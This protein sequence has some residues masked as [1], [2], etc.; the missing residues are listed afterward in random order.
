MKKRKDVHA[1]KTKSSMSAINNNVNSNLKLFVD[2]P[3]VK[4]YIID[5]N[6]ALKTVEFH[7]LDWEKFL[8]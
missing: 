4:I 7:E 6:K 3:H 5:N 8:H 1:I 2:L